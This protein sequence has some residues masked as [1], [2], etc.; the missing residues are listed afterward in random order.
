ML[1]GEL[2]VKK[3]GIMISLLIIF[4]TGA[5]VPKAES[6]GS[7]SYYFNGELKKGVYAPMYK[8]G[9]LLLPFED[10]F[11]FFGVKV[12]W[13]AKKQKATVQLP[14]NNTTLIVGADTAVINGKTYKINGKLHKDKT[15]MI[16]AELLEDL[17]SAKIVATGSEVNVE[18]N[19]TM[20]DNHI[21]MQAANG[22]VTNFVIPV[23]NP[24]R[25]KIQY[26]LKIPV[27]YNNFLKADTLSILLPPGESGTFNITTKKT[28]S[29]NTS[30]IFDVSLVK[31]KTQM[32]SFRLEV[33][34]ESYS[35]STHSRPNAF[36]N[37]DALLKAKQRISS[38]GWANSYWL[39]VKAEADKLLQKDLT[40]PSQAAGHSSWYVC[41]NGT[42]L[43]YENGGH[44][45]PSEKLFYF[46]K[47]YDA[48]WRFYR[49][50]ELVQ[51][52]KTLS[53][54]YAI[55]GDEK[56]AAA[57][58]KI[59]LGYAQSYPAYETQS[60]GGKLYWQSLDEAVSMIDIIQAYDFLFNSKNFTDDEKR[61]VELNLILSS[62]ETLK[63]YP[64][65]KSNWQAWHNT[66][67]AMAGFATGYQS[68][69]N[70][71]ID[72][73]IG[74]NYLME[75]GV[76]SDGFWWEGSLAYHS[77]TLAPLNILAEGA[78]NWG[79]NLFE[80]E[81]LKKMFDVPILYSYPNFVL[82]SNN[83]GGK[84]GTSLINSISSRGF[85]EYESAFSRYKDSSYGWLLDSKYKNMNRGGDFALFFGEAS[86]ASQE[87]PSISSYN[88][89]NIGHA[90]LRSDAENVKDQ[91]FIMMDYGPHGG[92]HGHYDKLSID[93]F[94]AGKMLA[95]DFGTP[96]YS[97]PLYRTWYKQTL[98]HNTVVIDGKSQS[99]SSGEMVAYTKEHDYQYMLANSPG[100]YKGIHYERSVWMN[101]GYVLDWFFVADNKKKHTYDYVLHGMGELDVKLKPKN[102]SVASIEYSQN[103]YDKLTDIK[104][105]EAGTNFLATWNQDRSGFNQYSLVGGKSARV[106]TAIGPGPSNTPE[107][108]T[109]LMVQRISDH[110]A[111]FINVYQPYSE[112]GNTLSV[113]RNGNTVIV[114]SKEE[115]H[116]YYRNKTV[117]NNLQLISAN[118]VTSKGIKLNLEKDITSEL[119]DGLLKIEVKNLHYMESLN[120]LYDSK[121]VKRVLLN[122]REVK[123]IQQGNQLLISYKK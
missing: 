74:F 39:K 89:N 110:K 108:N 118:A 87:R 2:L 78:L 6:S 91:I 59:L 52:L 114:N 38:P 13:D 83:D 121:Q 41:K 81:P 79:Y 58:K 99:E 47:K 8:S 64:M 119:K 85:N 71:A 112:T 68:L 28:A 109:S 24:T 116:H 56:Y 96:A 111:D 7:I 43:V 120:I 42:P 45:C 49:H 106:L 20:Y 9:E 63:S 94:G 5:S 100:A 92:S 75:K 31:G 77:Y 51:A 18:Y 115:S 25:Q 40:V 82:P 4:L 103:G 16:S 90:I 54:A 27:K 3:Y 113:I 53:T 10:T 95:P 65:D 117:N 34:S 11:K 37:R 12:I 122:G 80:S 101:S 55:S 48:G 105:Y 62:A 102:S 93:F 69:I 66:A 123:M 98:S 72:G 44:Y 22:D 26:D 17:T 84:F 19:E 60:R 35:L 50:N 88:F 76:L 32:S 104:E 36:I 15:Y 107:K 23:D 21:K 70:E 46:G 86:I 29:K 61:S 33:A 57:G 1:L 14:F 73:N 67:I 30:Q 97:H